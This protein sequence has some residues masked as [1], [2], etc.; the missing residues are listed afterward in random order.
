MS[1]SIKGVTIIKRNKD[2]KALRKP[3]EKLEI[4][5]LF[6]DEPVKMA[7][8]GKFIRETK[9]PPVIPQTTFRFDFVNSLIKV[10]F[11]HSHNVGAHLPALGL[12]I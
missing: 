1:S 5:E 7:L 11:N 4:N 8:N 12:S 9:I 10:M 2:G 3:S 6:T